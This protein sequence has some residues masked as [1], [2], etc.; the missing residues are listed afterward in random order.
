L[1]GKHIT[2]D[3]GQTYSYVTATF[4]PRAQTVSVIT[5]HGEVIHEDAFRVSTDLR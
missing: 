2:L 5:L 1:F 4:R 3:E